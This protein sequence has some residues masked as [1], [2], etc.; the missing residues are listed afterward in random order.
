MPDDYPDYPNHFQIARYFDDYV[1]HFGL[2]EKIHFRTE[3]KSVAPVEGEWEVVVEDA[4]GRQES[5]R[6][7]AVLV[8][9]GHHWN[10]RWP[11]PPFPGSDEFGGEQIHVHHYREPEALRDKRASCWGSATRQPTSRLR[12]RG[13]P[14]KPSWRCGEAPTSCP[15]T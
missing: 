4:D 14:R 13:S 11:E 3:V 9:N 6:Y 8:A 10:P 5:R 7:R 12:P 2:R 15:S 1:D